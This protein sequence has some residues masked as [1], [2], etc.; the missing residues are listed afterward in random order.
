MD[1][2][3]L[4]K[5]SE[6]SEIVTRT[7]KDSVLCDI[8]H[9]KPAN[10]QNYWSS[11]L[12]ADWFYSHWSNNHFSSQQIDVNFGTNSSHFLLH[13]QKCWNTWSE[14][15]GQISL[16]LWV[17]WL[18]GSSCDWTMFGRDRQVTFSLIIIIKPHF[19]LKWWNK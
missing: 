16:L 19:I 6:N 4:M 9:R 2:S 17:M 11:S 3:V 10:D 15:I 12:F 7:Q 5:M 1:L 13:D 14:I 8:N 18:T